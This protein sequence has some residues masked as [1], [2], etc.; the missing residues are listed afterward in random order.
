MRE[1]VRGLYVITDGSNTPALLAKV[2][3]AL[4]G[5]ATMVQYRDKSSDVAKRQEEAHAIVMLCRRHGALSFINDDVTL[6]AEVDADGVHVGRDDSAIAAARATLPGKLIGVSCYNQIELALAAQTAGADY[7]AFGRFFPS[8]TKPDAVQADV[9]LL[10]VAK[11]LL[12]IP[13]VAIGGIT[14][15][16]GRGL[17]A[18]GADALAVIHAVMAHPDVSGAARRFASLF[19]RDASQL[20][21][22]PQ[23]MQ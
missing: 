8:N 4:E 7:V 14:P 6:A 18:A 17:V 11:A 15:A 10:G 12:D 1:R 9:A 21:A 3:A 23:K 16:N 13:V 22:E 19:S 20:G 2:Q 5:G